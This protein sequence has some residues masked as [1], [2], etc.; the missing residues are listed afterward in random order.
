MMNRRRRRRR[1]PTQEEPA[2]AGLP[3]DL[4]GVGQYG[5]PDRT[6]LRVVATASV[7]L[8]RHCCHDG[9]AVQ[10]RHVLA[11]GVGPTPF[12]NP[13]AIPGVKFVPLMVT[14]T[15]VPMETLFGVI[16]VTVTALPPEVPHA[17]S[18]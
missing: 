15:T 1:L 12:S 2:E 7:A 11:T 9:A 5:R 4:E 8:D 10:D 18:V 17:P 3:H 16:E 14:S 6:S 13:T